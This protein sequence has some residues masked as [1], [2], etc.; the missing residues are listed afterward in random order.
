MDAILDWEKQC[1]ECKK[2]VKP[3]PP[4]NVK[5][6]GVAGTG[7]IRTIKTL[8]QEFNKVMEMSD[9]PEN[10]KGKI[11]MCAPT[12]VAAF[13]IGCDAASVHKT[14]NIPVKGD[15]K[16]LTGEKQNQLEL[17]FE[18]VWL[19]IIDEISMVGCE[20]LAK[21]NGR[22]IQ[23]KL[24]DNI[25]ISKAQRDP[26]LQRPAFGGIGMVLCGDFGQLIPIM[27]HSLMD[28][29]A[30][31]IQDFSP[32][33]ERFSNKG[34]DLINQ[35]K[36]SIIL[37]KQ[38]RKIGGEYTELCLRLRNGNFSHKDHQKLQERNYD[39]GVPLKEKEQLE[40]YGN[41]LVT[42]NKQ[43]GSCNAK[44]LWETAKMHNN[45]FLEYMPKKLVT[46][47]SLLSN[48]KNLVV[49]SQQSI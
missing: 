27:Q 33:K 2:A 25:D 41:T 6:L 49:L 48:L 40:K 31:T 14:F 8:V 47:A 36:I 45:K 32:Q 34:K 15:L 46:K 12:G 22:L 39:D 24:D 7:K 21:V 35:F 38:H 19:V 29:S 44:N 23:A 43:A 10:K 30:V 18:N 16:D 26:S 9:I 42:T 3:F 20:M 17:D 4:L 13:N 28:D 1:I 5:L 37:T 11:V